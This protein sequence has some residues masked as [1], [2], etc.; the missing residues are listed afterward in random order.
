MMFILVWVPVGTSLV[1]GAV[2]LAFGES[3]PGRKLIGVAVF[4]VAVYL[5]FFTRFSL[6]GMLLQIVIALALAAWRKMDSA[7]GGS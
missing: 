3:P 1:L 6:I 4:L 7:T 2:W 5:Q